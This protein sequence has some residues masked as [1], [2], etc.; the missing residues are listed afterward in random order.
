MFPPMG[1]ALSSPDDTED[2]SL[3]SRIKKQTEDFMNAQWIPRMACTPPNP[4]RASSTGNQGGQQQDP[5]EILRRRIDRKFKDMDI[6]GA[7]REI[8]S[9]EKLAP[10]SEETLLKLI[11]RHPRGSDENA[12]TPPDDGLHH[13]P[14]FSTNDIRNALMS[15][16]AGS[17]G[18]PDGLTP[19]HL[20]TLIAVNMAETGQQLLTSLRDFSAHVAAGHVP[21]TIRPIFLVPVFVH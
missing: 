9:T 2:I 14:L 3:T 10:F 12:P 21:D 13:T 8:S 18:G 17:S 4:E 19:G 1:P 20:R 11:E 6:R 5:D 16:P 15:F 7:I